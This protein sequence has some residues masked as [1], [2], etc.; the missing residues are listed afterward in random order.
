[1]NYKAKLYRIFFQTF[2]SLH[3]TPPTPPKKAALSKT[4]PPPFDIHAVLQVSW[5]LGSDK[6]ASL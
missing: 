3:L 6:F 2:G 1:M 5:G 4:P